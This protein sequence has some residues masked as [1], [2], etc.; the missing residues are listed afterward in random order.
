[1]DLW[2]S[3]KW[4]P[5]RIPRPSQSWCWNFGWGS[6]GNLPENTELVKLELSSKVSEVAKCF[7]NLTVVK[8]SLAFLELREPT[9][10]PRS[11]FH[12]KHF[13]TKPKRLLWTSPSSFLGIAIPIHRGSRISYQ[14]KLFNCSLYSPHLKLKSTPSPNLHFSDLQRRGACKI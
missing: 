3:F 7:L 10:L 9:S 11:R 1:M 4:P 8:L 5:C 2:S 6:L 14:A 12:R 13:L